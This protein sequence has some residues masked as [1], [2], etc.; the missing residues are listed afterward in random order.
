M[1]RPDR[2][3]QQRKSI[4]TQTSESTSLPAGIAP[5]LAIRAAA[6]II[7]VRSPAQPPLHADD[8]QRCDHFSLR[9]AQLG[10]LQVNQ[11][12]PRTGLRNGLW[13]SRQRKM[14]SASAE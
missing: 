14:V 1:W 11:I 6:D 8:R 12:L 3:T 2:G 7:R 5:R 13:C 10:S 4:T 9:G